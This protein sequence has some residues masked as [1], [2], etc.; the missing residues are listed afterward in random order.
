MDYTLVTRGRTVLV[1]TEAEPFAAALKKT[2]EYRA[3]RGAVSAKDHVVDTIPLR[4]G[5][6]LENGLRLF[7]GPAGRPDI[8]LTLHFSE[9]DAGMRISMEGTEGCAFQFTFPA[10]LGAGVFG[11]GEQYRKINLHG[12]TSSILVSG[13]ITL[14]TVLEKGILPSPLVG[15]KAREG[16]GTYAPIPTY[17]F[18]DGCL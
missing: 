14:P 7:A 11:G 8:S 1:H 17:V 13:H 18:G 9:L 16:I 2:T 3:S 12:H 15:L 6:L 5:E 10:D 4:D